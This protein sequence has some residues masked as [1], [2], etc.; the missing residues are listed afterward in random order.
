MCVKCRKVLKLIYIL[1]DIIGQDAI[2]HKTARRG[3]HQG[4]A[5]LNHEDSFLD[6]S[7]LVEPEGGDCHG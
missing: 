1:L 5:Y 4:R 3:V 2:L 6:Q 7:L